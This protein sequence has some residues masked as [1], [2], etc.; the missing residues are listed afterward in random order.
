MSR[1][2]KSTPQRVPLCAEF[3]EDDG[4]DPRLFFKQGSDQRDD[5]KDRQLC[6]QVMRTL[7]LVLAT[8]ADSRVRELEVQSVVPAPDSSRLLVRV[9]TTETT[10]RASSQ[11]IVARLQL[12]Q[13]Y[14][15]AEVAAAICRKRA[16]E[17][18]FEVAASP[19]VRP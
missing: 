4:I 3:H 17:L 13:P 16:P 6:K 1:R 15:R 7:R 14:L 8:C 10:A 9:C 12:A 2:K 18:A 5:R 11:D 19:E